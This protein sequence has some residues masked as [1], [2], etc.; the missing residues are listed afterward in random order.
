MRNWSSEKINLLL[1][2]SSGL[3]NRCLFEALVLIQLAMESHAKCFVPTE[4][5]DVI[6]T[7]FSFCE[8]FFCGWT[9]IRK[10]SMAYCYLI[11][12]VEFSISRKSKTCRTGTWSRSSPLTRVLQPVSVLRHNSC[13]NKQRVEQQGDGREQGHLKIKHTWMMKDLWVREQEY[14]MF[15]WLN[16]PD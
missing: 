8:K 14:P 13:L 15:W 4:S 3:L 10:I 2:T 9:T 6:F 11:F 16:V 12:N 5:N 7:V 1:R